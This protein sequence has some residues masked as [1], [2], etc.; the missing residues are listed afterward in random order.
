[1]RK[2]DEEERAKQKGDA[3]DT[4]LGKMVREGD[5]RQES[6]TGNKR[7]IYQRS[8]ERGSRAREKEMP[9]RRFLRI[10]PFFNA[11]IGLAGAEAQ[12][13]REVRGIQESKWQHEMGDLIQKETQERG[14]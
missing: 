7:Y 5:I 1:M 6:R 10:P 4:E 14:A 9:K 13:I 3:R 12:W 2:N 8:R 11:N